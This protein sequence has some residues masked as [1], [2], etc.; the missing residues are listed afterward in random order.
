MAEQQT[1]FLEYTFT[2]L[3]F[4]DWEPS[5]SNS[6]SFVSPI[7]RRQA[8][9]GEVV[10][11]PADRQAIAQILMAIGRSSSARVAVQRSLDGQARS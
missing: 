10:T 7:G 3:V 2:D 11:S 8:I 1:K 6:A 4:N 5:S 9:R